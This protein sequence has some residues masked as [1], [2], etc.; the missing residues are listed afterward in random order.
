MRKWDTRASSVSQASSKFIEIQEAWQILKNPGER[1]RARVSVRAGLVLWCH[2]YGVMVMVIVRATGVCHGFFNCFISWDTQEAI[3]MLIVL[4]CYGNGKDLGAIFVN[5]M[6]LNVLNCPKPS[7][8]LNPSIIW[9]PNLS[10]KP[11][12]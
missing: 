2:R 5:A 7:P 9:S 4:V 6:S 8:S 12:P 3:L 10:P 1:V 11:Q